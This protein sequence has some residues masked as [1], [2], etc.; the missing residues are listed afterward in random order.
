[1]TWQPAGGYG[2]P[3]YNDNPF[4]FPGTPGYSQNQ[5]QPQNWS[6]ST[7]EFQITLNQP[8]W[9]EAG[10]TAKFYVYFVHNI[11]GACASMTTGP[12]L[13]ILDGNG[14]PLTSGVANS[15]IIG[16][17]TA[18]QA[19]GIWFSDVQFTSS[20]QP[21]K[22]VAQWTASYTP[23]NTQEPQI[24]LPI[25]IRRALTLKVTKQPSQWFFKR[26]SDF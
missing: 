16:T 12:T 1:M 2:V 14:T 21:G 3:P 19:P 8:E 9:V 23:V 5:A 25:Q 11:D 4:T 22:Y 10:T 17:V 15:V 18:G 13:K 6:E 7:G 24:P 20:M 26:V